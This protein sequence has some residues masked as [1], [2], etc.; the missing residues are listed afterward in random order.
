MALINKKLF[1]RMFKMEF[2]FFFPTNDRGGTHLLGCLMQ[3]LYQLGHKIYSNIPVQEF[4][5]N[6]IYPPFKGLFTDDIEITSDMSR[7]HLIVNSYNGLGSFLRPLVNSARKNKI[8]LVDMNDSS[9]FRDYDDNFLVFKTHF[10]KFALRQ[11]RIHPIGFGVSQEAINASGSYQI[12]KRENDILRNFRPSG[13][14]SVRDSLDLILIPKLKMHFSVNENISTQNQYL[15]DLLT[16]RAVLAYGGLIYKDLRLNPYFLGEKIYQFKELASEPVILRFDSW[17]YYE[18]ALFG[19]CPISLDFERYGLDTSANPVPW[20][21]YV[22]I[23]FSQINETV[24]RIL[25]SLNDDPMFFE[26][27]GSNARDWILKNHSPKS[28]AQRLLDT[29]RVEGYL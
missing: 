28:M 18:S 27:I 26:N 4:R 10:N 5:S 12:H 1:R 11:G 3:G 20:K 23:D 7:G 15:I 19:A 25:V 21:E 29:M 14:Q 13:E 9:N 6:G 16:H 2:S 24:S 17:R 8:V 22:P